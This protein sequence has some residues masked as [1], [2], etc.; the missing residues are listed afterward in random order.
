LGRGGQAS[1]SQFPTKGIKT[2]FGT[3]TNPFEGA[4]NPVLGENVPAR[5]TYDKDPDDE[6]DISCRR[7]LSGRGPEDIARLGGTANRLCRI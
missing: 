1:D 6:T 3:F 4:G 2:G 7:L 5:L